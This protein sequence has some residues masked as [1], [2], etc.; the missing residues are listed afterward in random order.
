[1]TDRAYSDEDIA[2]IG[3]Y[4]L[5]LLPDAEARDLE[6]RLAREPE[7]RVLLTEWENGLAGLADEFIPVKPPAA[8]KD[9]VEARLFGSP[10]RH[11]P[12]KWLGA[13]AG[14]AAILAVVFVNLPEAPTYTATIV[15]ADQSLR[16]EASYDENDGTLKITRMQGAARE[17]RALELWLIAENAAV[18]VSL[19]VLP[20][21][22]EARINLA[23]PL[24]NALVNGTLAVSDEPEG[25]SPTGAPTGD[26]LAVGKVITL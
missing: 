26:V 11:F 16:F 17:G 12:F 8:L 13:L 25:G 14:I 10:K 7:L 2:L 1:M 6:A 20:A 23:A 4:A 18:P 9:A 5:R 24:A 22:P 19:G 3:E 21:E 15:A